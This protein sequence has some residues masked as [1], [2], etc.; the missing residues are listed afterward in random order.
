M[1]ITPGELQSFLSHFIGTECYYRHWLKVIVYT[2]GIKAMA[3]KA[4]AHWLIDAIA[5][6]QKASFRE[7][8]PFQVWRLTVEG[9]KA[10]LVMQEDQGEPIIVRQEIEYTDFPEGEWKFYLID[11]VLMLP[12]EY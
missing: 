1:A 4:G 10:V 9:S 12:G 3:E 7:K 6:Y 5:S 2:D 8:Y 11:E